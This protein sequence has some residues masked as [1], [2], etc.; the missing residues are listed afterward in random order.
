VRAYVINLARSPERRAHMVAE[1]GKTG[2]DYEIVQAVDGRELDF[3][4]PRTVANIEPSVLG[5]QA[6]DGQGLDSTLLLPNQIACVLSHLH[7][8]RKILDDGSEYGFVFED[9]VI[10]PSDLGSL[11]DAI[12]KHLAGAE[13]VLLNFDSKGTCRMT[14]E[15]SVELPDSRLLVL[16]IDVTDPVSGAA[17]IITRQACER[18][19]EQLLPV[20]AKVDDWAQRY[21]EGMLDRVR[22]VVPL[23]VNKSTAFGSTI[24]YYSS[25][26]LKA[27]LLTAV[28]RYDPGILRKA[29]AYR[30]QRI[31]RSWSK[32]EFVD[33]PFV[34]K[35]S[36]LD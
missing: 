34:N 21:N 27:R 29:I 20:R 17:Y 12:A 28:M 25:E 8:Y 1:L 2:V 19:I 14:R 10:L 5:G 13:I 4:D 23:P 30:R 11:A 3:D 36:R 9:D 16:P 18:M 24:E 6:R 32:V 26:S 35:P 31:W 7:A 15:G 22:C 33:M